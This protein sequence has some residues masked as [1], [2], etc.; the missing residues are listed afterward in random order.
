VGDLSE[1]EDLS[2][3]DNYLQKI[4]DRIGEHVR[5][6]MKLL[7]GWG[8]GA[9]AESTVSTGRHHRLAL[10]CDGCGG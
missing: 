4:P 5:H 2:L 9:Y 6:N 1:L 7:G 10:T 3:A 8:M